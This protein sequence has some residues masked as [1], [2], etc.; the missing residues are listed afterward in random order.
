ME[1]AKLPGGDV[2]EPRT[3]WLELAVPFSSAMARGAWRA[4]S[5]PTVTDQEAIPHRPSWFTL[6]ESWDTGVPSPK[7]KEAGFFP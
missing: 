4:P 1:A 2:L 5:T 3:M 7:G 6:P